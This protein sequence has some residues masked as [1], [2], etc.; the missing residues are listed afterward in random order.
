MFNLTPE[1]ELSSRAQKI[2]VALR[3]TVFVLFAIG[4]AAIFLAVF[5]PV[6]NFNF[7][8]RAAGALKN[9]VISPRN[10]DAQPLEKG[11]LAKNSA[12]RFDTP[13]AG[14]FSKVNAVFSL[15]K[16]APP[17]QNGTLSI[18]KSFQSF[19]YPEGAPMSFKEGSLV[20]HAGDYFIV[21]GE[22]FRKF[23]FT[24]LLRAMGYNLNA[25]S[26]ITAEEMRLNESG[27]KIEISS[28][29]PASTLFKINNDYYQ[30]AGNTLYKFV[31]E[32][33]YLTKYDA[34][35][36]I[37][38]TEDF[39]KDFTLAENFFGF[40]DGTLVSFGASVYITSQDKMLPFADA[41]TFQALGY[42]W[43]D[44]LPIDSAEASVYK[45]GA[46]FDLAVPHPDGTIFFDPQEEKYFSI[47]ERKKR[48]LRGPT[49]Q[50]SYL[51]RRAPILASAAG[52]EI[53]PTCHLEKKLSFSEKYGCQIS[54]EDLQTLFG[55]DYQFALVADEEIRLKEIGITFQ[56]NITWSNLRLALAEIK[57]KI[58]L[59]YGIQK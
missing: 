32:K 10:N 49:I 30:I 16:N 58:L 35:Q 20:K 53:Q 22:K 40:A 57:N 27:E 38:K 51:L 36:A 56:Q 4:A 48:E 54:L 18:R 43:D 45:K 15:E 11:L 42:S 47:H 9:T 39:L 41:P 21:S 55:N 52:L 7:S 28:K 24:E 8:F 46:V 44:V 59:R 13:L 37:E 26:E 50:K 23:A 6:R 14:D 33:A 29:Y 2:Y 17:L 34:A 3:I 1:I 12:L 25:F 19:F 31:S 5:F